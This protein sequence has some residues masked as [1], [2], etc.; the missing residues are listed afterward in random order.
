MLNFGAPAAAGGLFGAMTQQAMPPPPVPVPE[1]SR[2]S[3]GVS[4]AAPAEEWLDVESTGTKTWAQ[5]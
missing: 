1:H 5:T 3:R 2:R 4:D